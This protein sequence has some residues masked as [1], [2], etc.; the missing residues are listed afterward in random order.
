MTR[1]EYEEMASP[2]WQVATDLAV[3]ALHWDEA[4]S[5]YTQEL[6]ACCYLCKTILIGQALKDAELE[7]ELGTRR[8]VYWLVCGE[9][10]N[11]R[12][13]IDARKAVLA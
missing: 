11:V 10:P 9:C 12:A 13:A 5:A 2:R 4:A 7:R 3:I 6:A 8:P 1:Q